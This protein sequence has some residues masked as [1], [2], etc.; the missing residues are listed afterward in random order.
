MNT[1]Q[2][3]VRA[4]FEVN[5]K[6]KA[7]LRNHRRI[8]ED[9]EDPVYGSYSGQLPGEMFALPRSCLVN[10]VSRSHFGPIRTKPFP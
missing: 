8:S 9:F 4:Q 5:K 10:R 1:L 3:T 7:R 2:D 6:Q